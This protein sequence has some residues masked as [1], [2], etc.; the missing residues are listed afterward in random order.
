MFKYKILG[1]TYNI[2]DELKSIRPLNKNFNNRWFFSQDTK[3]WELHVQNSF[4]TQTF[5]TRLENFCIKYRLRLLIEEYSVENS[6]VKSINDFA[7]EDAFFDYFHSSNNTVSRS[8][9]KFK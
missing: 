3:S 5:I 8:Q 2:K 1:N 7:S 4:K 9:K 6:N